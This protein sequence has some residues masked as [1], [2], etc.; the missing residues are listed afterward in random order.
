MLEEVCKLFTQ[1]KVAKLPHKN[2]PL[3]VKS[4]YLKYRSISNKTSSVNLILLHYWII[5]DVLSRSLMF[6]PM[7]FVKSLSVKL[8]V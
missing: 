2:T 5:I 1:V 4:L 6:D 3:P 7:L 8:Q